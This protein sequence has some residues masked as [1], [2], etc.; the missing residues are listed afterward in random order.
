MPVH[1]GS[2]E[3]LTEALA[4]ALMPYA[5]L[6]LVEGERGL[7]QASLVA[8]AGKRHRKAMILADGGVHLPYGLIA[9][10]L[11]A[12]RPLRGEEVAK[13]A[14]RVRQALLSVGR[15]R[16][17]K[18]GARAREMAVAM[19]HTLPYPLEARREAL[20]LVFSLEEAGLLAVRSYLFLAGRGDRPPQEAQEGFWLLLWGWRR[21]IQGRRPRWEPALYGNI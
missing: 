10:L 6:P 12:G 19:V 9:R 21:L 4:Q 8:L 2:P 5:G 18:G 3:E 13:L 7:G 14:E 17:W 20:R 11:P 15:Q 16:E 1:L